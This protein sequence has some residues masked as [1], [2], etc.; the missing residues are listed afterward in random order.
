MATAAGFHQHA[1]A[2]AVGACEGSDLA[3]VAAKSCFYG[4]NRIVGTLDEEG[5]AESQ[6]KTAAASYLMTYETKASQRDML[7]PARSS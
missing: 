4:P 5:E 7:G 2:T 6:K 3:K 1:A